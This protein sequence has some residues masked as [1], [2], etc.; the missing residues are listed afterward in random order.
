M[1]LPILAAMSVVS[2][3]P[4]SI[5]LYR[6]VSLPGQAPTYWEVE[7]TTLDSTQADLDQGYAHELNGADGKNIL[8]QFRGLNRAIGPHKKIVSASILFTLSGPD[9]G[10]FL[11]ASEV[12]LPWHEGPGKTLLEM[13]PG[14]SNENGARWS[15]T[16]RHRRLGIAGGSWEH[17]GAVG[18]A[19][20]RLIPGAKLSRPDRDHV[21]IDGLTEVVQRQ[22]DE[23]WQNNGFLL[24]FDQPIEVL[25]S[26][27]TQDRPKLLLQVAD[28]APSHGPDLTIAYIERK[29]EYPRFQDEGGYSVMPQDGVDI[30][31]LDHPLNAVGKKWPSDG[32]DVVYIGHVKNV[33]DAPSQ[34]FT[35]RW[36]VDEKPS[37]SKDMPD[38]LLPGQEALVTLHLPFKSDHFDHRIQPV[39]LTIEPKG[40]D[41]ISANNSLEIQQ[42]ALNL[43]V[44]VEKSFY[45]KAAAAENEVGSHCFEDCIQKRVELLNSVYFPFSKFSFAPDGATERVRIQRI[46]VVPD[47]TLR[48]GAFLPD[49]KSDLNYD[50]ELGLPATMAL[51][52]VTPAYLCSRLGLIDH[53]KLNVPAGSASI[54]IPDVNRGTEDLFP[55][56]MGEGDTRDDSA[57][58]PTFSIPYQPFHETFSEEAGLRPTDLLSA[59][60]V[61]QLVS[62]LG[63]RGGVTGDVLYD[64]PTEIALSVVDYSGARLPKLDLR[65]YQMVNGSF[66]PNAPS[67]TAQTDAKGLLNL[68]IHDTGAGK[69]DPLPTGHAL[70][71]NPFGRIDYLDRNGTYLV[72]AE[73]NG[74]VEWSTLKLWELVDT[75]HRGQKDLG[76]M[77][78]AFNLPSASLDAGANVAKGKSI[79]DS[80]STPAE[81][82]SPLLDGNIGSEVDIAPNGWLEVDLGR[83]RTIGE[84]RLLT[85]GAPFWQQFEIRSYATAEKAQQ[86][87]LWAKEGSWTWSLRNRPDKVAAKPGV[88]SIAY[89]GP[90]RR[91]RYIRIVNTGP[92]TAGRLMQIEAIPIS[93]P[94]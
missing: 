74:A 21:Q 34:G 54:Q 78:L 50:A 8:I 17:A 63:K 62:D 53:S 88:I 43:G 83:D 27:A 92:A 69:E 44:Y 68:F 90:A 22:Y 30:P 5:E 46:I 94:G 20:S 42:A 81:K 25:S 35:A 59:T 58:P 52:Q 7:D 6:G 85:K 67:Y 12:L 2:Q 16:W 31:V 39:A 65:F 75:Y 1:L 87:Q 26:K 41:A 18:S 13:A 28:V 61:A 38:A 72:R 32:E 14:Q 73:A 37:T 23:P 56:I 80:E 86:S 48:G 19:D 60:D 70:R 45:D 24:R 29:P 77:S 91:F 11:S 93:A 76:L 9:S 79:S 49:G 15:A 57:I 10:H 55:G 82:L 51:E 47:G 40:A 4:Q 89:R 36:S 64:T 33:G 71:P 66:P 3:A 84:I